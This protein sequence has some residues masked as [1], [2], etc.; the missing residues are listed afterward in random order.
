[1]R[2]LRVLRPRRRSSS[3]SARRRSNMSSRS[4]TWSVSRSTMRTVIRR[5]SAAFASATEFALLDRDDLGLA[6][7][8]LDGVADALA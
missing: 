8:H 2:R 1:V 5:A 4:A 3:M 6:V 7:H